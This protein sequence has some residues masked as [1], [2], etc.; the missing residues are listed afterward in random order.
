MDYFGIGFRTKRSW[1]DTNPDL[2]RLTLGSIGIPVGQRR[3]G[4]KDYSFFCNTQ[5]TSARVNQ[6]PHMDAQRRIGLGAE[7]VI[8][9][10]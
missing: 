4:P 9:R 7:C 8:V 10:K 2:Q 3:H 5:A 1:I 6:H